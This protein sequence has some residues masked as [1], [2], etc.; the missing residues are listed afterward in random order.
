MPRSDYKVVASLYDLLARHSPEEFR[1]ASR[2]SE[3][4]PSLAQVADILSR[5]GRAHGS[6][7]SAQERSRKPSTSAPPSRKRPSANRSRR[8]QTTVKNRMLQQLKQ[9][10]AVKSKAD[11]ARIVDLYKL[12]LTLSAKD[13]FDRS[14]GRLAGALIASPQSL[15]A[16]AHDYNI[17]RDEQ[18][19]GWLRL[20][21][22]N[23]G[24]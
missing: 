2:S 6:V 7:H 1:R 21:M 20:I 12:D 9:S 10:R 3:L 8:N 5:Y 23:G 18:T 16:F 15:R 4:G 17:G 13:S 22:G 19:R 11:I 24:E 14:L